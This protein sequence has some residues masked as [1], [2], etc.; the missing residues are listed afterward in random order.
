MAKK[1][2]TKLIEREL[3]KGT[4]VK[5]KFEPTD[6]LSCGSTLGNL[7][8][9]GVRFG[10][11][12]KGF[13]H[14]WVGDSDT[15]KTWIAM[16]ALAEACHNPAFDGYRIIY[17]SVE[18]GALMD[19]E[20]Y[21]GAETLDRLEAPGENESNSYLLED[22]YFHLDDAIQ[23]QEPFIYVLDS[24]DALDSMK[25]QDE[26]IAAKR[27]HRAGNQMPGSYGDGKAKMNK[28]TIK[29]YLTPLYNLNSILIILN[30][31]IDKLDA[32]LFESKKTVAGGHGLFFFSAATVWLSSRGKIKQTLRGKEY[33]IGRTTKL[34]VTRSRFV[35]AKRAVEFPIYH[36][37][38]IDDIGSCVDYL[39]E[40]KHWPINAGI[41]KVKELK[42]EF[43]RDDLIKYIED[44]GHEEKL[45]IITEKVWQ[46]IESSLALQ[47]KRRY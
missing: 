44:K 4:S 35:G 42:K 24:M 7:A 33:E 19:I 13:Y 16:N 27:E 40:K 43:K 5:R 29:K 17:D 22:F 18:G 47:R 10:A 1:K 12:V 41:I 23:K 14:Y 34:G 32:G 39:V 25:S 2:A 31:T 3:L 38:G 21:F 30:Q 20:K 8:C 37:Y 46:E 45:K 11:F 28:Q 26:F 9:T 15:G 36:S 6:Y